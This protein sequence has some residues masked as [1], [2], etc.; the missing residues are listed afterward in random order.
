[1]VRVSVTAKL[2]SDRVGT[3]GTT[4]TADGKGALHMISLPAAGPRK[5]L[6]M[7]LVQTFGPVAIPDALTPP[8]YVEF[9][10]R[11]FVQNATTSTFANGVLSEFKSTDP[12]VVAPAITLTTD[13]LKSVV[14]AV[15]LTR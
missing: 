1:M 14:L 12:S 11:T 3:D 6:P 5:V 2:L 8:S 7:A 10:R 4:K 9:G 13:L 15:P